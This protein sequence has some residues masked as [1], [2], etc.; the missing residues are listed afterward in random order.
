VPIHSTQRLNASSAELQR[1][2]VAASEAQWQLQKQQECLYNGS[3][4][5]FCQ[6][7]RHQCI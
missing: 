6:R 3:D 2:K 4:E 1:Q 7:F 5:G